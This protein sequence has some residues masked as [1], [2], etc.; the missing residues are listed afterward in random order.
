MKPEMTPPV[1][2]GAT[3]ACGAYLLIALADARVATIEE[4]R[5]LAGMINDPAFSIFETSALEAEYNRLTVALRAD[6]DNAE[7]EILSAI[8][9]VRADAGAAR[10]VRIAAQHAII[11][12]Q[13]VKPQEELELERIARALGVDPG[14]L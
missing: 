12:D 3:A 13:V 14:T 6:W 1:S 2:P 8:A 11:A 10:A 9:T 7:A 4:A 5:F